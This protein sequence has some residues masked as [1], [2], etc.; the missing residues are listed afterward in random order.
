MRMKK[1][2][3]FYVS[4]SIGLGGGREIIRDSEQSERKI[5]NVRAMLCFD[6]VADMRREKIILR[7]FL[8]ELFISLIKLHV[9]AHTESFT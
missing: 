2:Q 6:P 1:L 9:F 8:S 5:V 3:K 4:S 7:D